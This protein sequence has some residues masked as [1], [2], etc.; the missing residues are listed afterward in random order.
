MSRRLRRWLPESGV[1]VAASGCRE[2]QTKPRRTQDKNSPDCSVGTVSPEGARMRDYPTNRTG[3]D[4][5]LTVLAATFLAVSTSAAFAQAD[6]AKRAPP[7]SQST[8]RFPRQSQPT[9]RRLRQPISRRM[10]CSL[11]HRWSA[12]RSPATKRPRRA[13]PIRSPPIQRQP[14][15][16]PRT[17]DTSTKP[18]QP[19][20]PM[21]SPRA[22][23]RAQ[24]PR[25]QKRSLTSPRLLPPNQMMSLRLRQTESRRTKRRRM[26]RRRTPPRRS[27]PR[28]RRLTQR[29]APRRPPI[30]RANQ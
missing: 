25:P 14:T 15:R 5:L 26:S 22:S 19:R 6:V 30:S 12:S 27:P 11:H 1:R 13:Q 24:T 20:L 2:G 7:N 29:P 16:P 8:Q 4:R 28:P 23:S 21:R 10:M 17:A 9:F 18:T 3:F